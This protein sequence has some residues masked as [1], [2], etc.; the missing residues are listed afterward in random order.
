MRTKLFALLALLIVLAMLV[1]A[2]APA[3]PTE[4]PAADQPAAA[5][6]PAAAAD[7]PSEPAADADAMAKPK[8]GFVYVAPIGD[9]GWTWAHDQARLV[10]EEE[11]GAETTYV[12]NVPEGPDAERVDPRPGAE[13]LQ[14]DLH[15]LLRVHGPDHQRRRR[16]P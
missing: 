10:L 14:P 6:Q 9:M 5:E 16:V 8:V 11:L 2:C 1:T 4:A 7:Q 13:G 15:H 3:A 12:E